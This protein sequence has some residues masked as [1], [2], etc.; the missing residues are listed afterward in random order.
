MRERDIFSVKDKTE[1][2]WYAIY[3]KPRF[4]KKVDSELDLAN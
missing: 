1:R 2:F 3:T 4:E